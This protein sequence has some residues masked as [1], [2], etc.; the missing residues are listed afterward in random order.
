MAIIKQP[1]RSSLLMLLGAP[2][3]ALSL[4]GCAAVDGALA[5]GQQALEQGRDTVESAAAGLEAADGLIRAGTELAAACTAA[6]AAWVPGVSTAD[7]RTAIGDALRIVDDVIA[8]T[9]GVPGATDIRTALAS[10]QDELATGD[11][12]LGL[13]RQTLQTACA[14]VSVGG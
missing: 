3:L 14:L 8:Q 12:T 10:A 5:E 4:A 1:L 6:Q 9:P 11:G 7:A 2:L 13:S